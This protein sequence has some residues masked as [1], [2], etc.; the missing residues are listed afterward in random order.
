MS[1]RNDEM[2]GLAF[3]LA[4]IGFAIYFVMIAVAVMLVLFALVISV[5][6]LLA[7]NRPLYLNIYT[8]Y[9]EEARAIIYWGLAGTIIAPAFTLLIWLFL[10]TPPFGWEVYAL[11]VGVGYVFGSVGINF[12][13]DIDETET[14]S[15]GPNTKDE[16][17]SITS[18]S[19]APSSGSPSLPPAKAKALPAPPKK[20]FRYA[21]WNDEE[22]RQ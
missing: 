12:L 3:V 21:S 4:I 6:A 9:P 2:A 16:T 10:D 1:Q 19:T 13:A 15:V 11:S 8:L 22:L 17:V 7:W 18:G 14:F 20:P 5:L